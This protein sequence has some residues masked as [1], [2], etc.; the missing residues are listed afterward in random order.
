MLVQQANMALAESAIQILYKGKKQFAAVVIDAD[1]GTNKSPKISLGVSDVSQATAQSNAQAAFTSVEASTLAELITNVKNFN[2]GTSGPL[3]GS[4][5]DDFIDLN[6]FD[7]QV[8]DA[9]ESDVI[10]HASASKFADDAGATNLVGAGWSNY[11]VWDNDTAGVYQVT[12]RIPTPAKGKGTVALVEVKG[13]TKKDATTQIT[14]GLKRTIYDNEGNVLFTISDATPTESE[15]Q[16]APSQPVVFAGP[17]IVRDQAL[18]S[19]DAAEVDYTNTYALWG[20][21]PNVQ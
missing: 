9:L 12:L 11:L 10:G 15:M 8:K 18:A 19:G 13:L 20:Y 2:Y 16:Y 14:N 3:G 17:V 1:G 4:E 6:D 5:N 7:C 21:P